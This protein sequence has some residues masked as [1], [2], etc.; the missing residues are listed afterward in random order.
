MKPPV[1]QH[2]SSELVL[3]L[4]SPT[5]RRLP[6]PRG[7][8]GRKPKESAVERAKLEA[9]RQAGGLVVEHHTTQYWR[10]SNCGWIYPDRDTAKE[11]CGALANRTQICRRCLESRRVLH[12][13]G[14]DGCPYCNK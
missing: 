3:E 5:D 9:T 11:C 7:K 14:D 1:P 12:R 10:C 13:I 4:L 8:I 2:Q 6:K